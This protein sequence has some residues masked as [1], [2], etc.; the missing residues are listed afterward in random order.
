MLGAI[1]SP[2]DAVAATSVAERLGLPRRV[3][4]ILEGESL[5]NDATAL[6]TYR[7]AVAAA[8]T[9]AFSFT[10][11]VGKFV[12]AALGGILV[13]LV[14][15]WIVVRLALWTQDSS[16]LI[17][18]TLLAPY[19][20]FILGERLDVSGVL[21]V[22]VVGFMISRGYFRLQNPGA[23]IQSVAFWDMYIFL[24]NGFVFILIGLQLPDVLDGI[25][26]IPW[27][28]VAYYAASGEPNRNP[29]AYRLGVSHLRLAIRAGR[30]A[31]CLCQARRPSE[32]IVISLAGMR[33][34]VSLAAALA[35]AEDVPG[36]DL[37]IFLTF[38]VI[39]VTLV[40]QGLTL[41]PLIRALGIAGNRD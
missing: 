1:V 30:T 31:T 32:L 18:I 19:A 5:V 17:A 37:I 3:I 29:R 7:V 20:A 4:A 10:D 8:V 40:A 35:L 39:L 36:R 25:S 33:G 2:T 41:A 22:V 28:T 38:A 13:G 24:L 15:G 27:T 11:A 16:I 12:L 23:R 6:V 26:G 9:G 21:A 34:V 14:V